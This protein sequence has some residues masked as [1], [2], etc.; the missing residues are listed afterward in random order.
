MLLVYIGIL[1]IL[2]KKQITVF[3]FDRPH[4]TYYINIIRSR[5]H[6][7]LLLNSINDIEFAS[8]DDTLNNKDMHK[9]TYSRILI[10][11]VDTPNS[12]TSPIYLRIG[13]N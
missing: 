8:H 7:V 10:V 3:Y 13:K 1:Y 9:I 12:Y 11:C 4:Y 6:V 5:R 2:T